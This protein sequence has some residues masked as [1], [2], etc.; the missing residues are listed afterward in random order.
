MADREA[1][2]QANANAGA[3]FAAALMRGL[4]PALRDVERVLRIWIEEYKRRVMRVT[5][6][7]K[8]LMRQSWFTT[9]ERTSRSME[10]TLANAVK[11]QD[12]Q[13][14]P[15][16]IEY[17]TDRIAKGKVKD[18][19]QGD[20]PIMDW[21]AKHE[22]LPNLTSIGPGSKKYDRH[23]DII[24]NAFTAGTGEQMPMLRPIGYEIAPKVVEDVGN[25]LAHGLQA[26]VQQRK[27]AG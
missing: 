27:A 7:D 12:G 9:F 15:L 21:P 13:P 20:A 19:K 8:G 2:F 14:Y 3:L 11:S 1:V 25:A 24:T 10:A 18:W 23:V 6:V 22:D 4:E 17:G 26:A 16:F 5:P